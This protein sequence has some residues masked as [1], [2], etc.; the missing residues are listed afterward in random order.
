M[1]MPKTQL[2]D[3]NSGY[4][5]VLYRRTKRM[6]YGAIAFENKIYLIK[7][8]ESPSIRHI[9]KDLSPDNFETKILRGK[10]AFYKY[11]IKGINGVLEIQKE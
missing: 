9:A 10:E 3:L 2:V 8:N 11:G 4:T 6:K 7:R 1:V 5:Y